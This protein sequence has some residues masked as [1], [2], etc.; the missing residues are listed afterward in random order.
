MNKEI[1]QRFEA[2]D[3]VT[4]VPI[5]GQEITKEQQRAFNEM[6]V[7]WCPGWIRNGGYSRRMSEI[8]FF[9]WLRTI[10][11]EHTHICAVVVHDKRCPLEVETVRGVVKQILRWIE[12]RRE[13]WKSTR[14]MEIMYGRK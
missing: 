8:R 12:L 11:L 13:Y 4:I 3:F 1:R 7:K 14:I 9:R 6:I 10:G 5:E 2:M